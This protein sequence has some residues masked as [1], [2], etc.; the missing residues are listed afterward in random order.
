MG[1]R[2]GEQRE[3]NWDNCNSII[4]KIHLKKKQARGP[5]WDL[6]IK[7]QG[8][9]DKKGSEVSLKNLQSDLPCPFTTLG[10]P[11]REGQ[12][13]WL[14]INRAPI[15]GPRGGLSCH[16]GTS[17][18]C[19]K[20]LSMAQVEKGVVR[21][22]EGRK[23]FWISRYRLPRPPLSPSTRSSWVSSYHTSLSD[24]FILIYKS[25]S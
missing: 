17:A 19:P 21:Q 8:P 4:N 24:Y 2:Q 6:E 12:G 9:I 10:A 20:P 5:E 18:W 7:I 22:K 14:C 13:S 1:T 3:K 15:A 11:I 23:G 16:V 25:V